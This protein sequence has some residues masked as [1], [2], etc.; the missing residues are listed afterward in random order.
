MAMQIPVLEREP[1]PI[2]H[3]AEK[4]RLVVYGEPGVGKTTLAMTF[5]RPF[6]INSDNGLIAVTALDPAATLGIEFKVRSYDDLTPL[7]FWLRDHADLFDTIV[8]DSIDE[9][10]FV[11]TTELIERVTT[12]DKRKEGSRYDPHPAMEFIPDQLL[13]QANQRQLHVLLV[14][15]ARLDKHIVVCSGVRP[16]DVPRVPKRQPNLAPAA[17]HDLMRWASIAG[18][19]AFFDPKPPATERVRALLTENGNAVRESK[20]RFSVLTPYVEAPT[21]EKL[22]QGS[23]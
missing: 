8:L 18:E 6:V 11:L 19:L 21:F 17:M 13:Y 7:Y 2:T 16:I 9:L 15:L 10:A 5:P 20:S 14:N 1:Q 22:N 3:A 4:L 23:K 12:R